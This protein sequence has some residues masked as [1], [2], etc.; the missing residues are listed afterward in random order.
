MNAYI[1]LLLEWLFFVEIECKGSWVEVK[2]CHGHH[3]FGSYL[4][5][6]ADRCE[7]RHVGK[8]WIQTH[9]RAERA[10]EHFKRENLCKQIK[11]PDWRVKPITANTINW[12]MRVPGPVIWAG[13]SFLY[14][15]WDVQITHTFNAA[16]FVNPS[17]CCRFSLKGWNLRCVLSLKCQ[18][19][20][21]RREDHRCA[22]VHA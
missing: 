6:A 12:I 17:V 18:L 11:N 2:L 21:Q 14:A 22:D 16:V 13:E 19:M 15:R 9:C 8:A 7:N 5:L 10:E 1:S 4:Q 20:L 3:P